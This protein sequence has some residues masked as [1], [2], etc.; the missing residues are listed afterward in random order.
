MKLTRLPILVFFIF[1]SILGTSQ[2]R[3]QDS[4]ALVALYSA[5]D[6]ANWAL[7]TNWLSGSPIN[8]W[9]GV[10]LNASKRV[11]KINLTGNNLTG[12]LPVKIGN[13]DALRLLYLNNNQLTG[14]IPDTLCHLINV[15]TID[16]SY[17]ELSGTIPAD[18]GG[19]ASLISLTL[20]HNH[21][22]GNLPDLSSLSTLEYLSLV[23][24]SFMFSDLSTS[25]L[26]PADIDVFQYSPQDTVTAVERN[27][28]SGTILTNII[29]DVHNTYHWYKN[30]S[31]ISESTREI[32]P[33]E[34]GMYDCQISNTNYPGL[35]L[36]S[37]TLQFS[38][39]VQSDSMVL[40]ALYNATNGTSW[41][42]H[43]NWLIGAMQ[44]W[45]GV[46]LDGNRR[47]S[48]IK[49]ERNNLIGVLPDE[50]GTLS[51][52]E[53]LK[54]R[55]N[56]LREGVPE[57]S[58]CSNLDTLII[59]ENQ[60][61][62]D[63][64]ETVDI[65]PGE[66]ATFTYYPQ[67]TLIPLTFNQ[68]ESMLTVADGQDSSN[69]YLWYLDGSFIDDSTQTILITMEASYHCVITNTIF[70]ELTLF[71]DTMEV[72]F[73]S[74]SDSLM[75]VKLYNETNGAQWANRTN[76]LT[77]R[78]KNWYGITVDSGNRVQKISLPHNKLMGAIPAQI[79]TLSHLTQLNLSNNQL[80]GEIPTEIEK[81]A[82][83]T[84]LRLYSNQLIG[85][86]PSGLGDLTDLTELGLHFNELTGTIPSQLFHLTNLQSLKLSNNQLSGD[87]PV[88]I[89][90]L[91]NLTWL[92][93]NDNLLTGTIPAEIGELPL[94]TGIDLD[95]NLFTGVI[96]TQIGNLTGLI[97]LSLNDNELTGTIPSGISNCTH[98]NFLSLSGNQLSGSIPTELTEL[99]ELTDLL[100]GDNGL[101]G[102]VPAGIGFLTSLNTLDLAKNQFTGSLPAELENLTGL[103]T[104][105]LDSNR[106]EGDL[107]L[108]TG[109]TYL[110]ELTADNNQFTFSNLFSSGILP[111][112]I[113]QFIYSP[114]DTIFG[115]DYDLIGSTLEALDDGETDNTF[116]W[117]RDTVQLSLTSQTISL[118]R[119]G[120]YHCLVNNPHYPDLTIPSDTFL[121][122]YTQLTDSVALVAFYDSTGGATWTNKTNWLTGKLSSWYGVTVS[123]ERVSKV[124]LNNNNLIGSLPPEIGKLSHLTVLQ[125]QNN[126]LD[127]QLPDEIGE[128]D[129]LSDLRLNNNQLT[130]T[131]PSVIG[132][133]TNLKTLY[134]NNNRFSGSIPS[135][136]GNLTALTYLALNSNQLT[137]AIPS[138][139]GNLVNLQTLNLNMNLL[140]GSLPDEIG[141][142]SS[143]QYL[144]LSNNNLSGAIPVVIGNLSLIK[145]INLSGNDFTGE[146]P[147]ETG[148]LDNLRVLNL[149]G[150]QLSGI[151]PDDLGYLS[152]LQEFN[153]GNN[154]YH[155]AA[156][157]PIFNWN[158]YTGFHSLFTYTPQA[159]IGVVDTVY[160]I[161]GSALVLSIEGY[162]T[163]NHDQFQW[164]KNDT[165]Q[166]GKTD[167]VFVISSFAS[168]NEGVYHC[169]V[170][171]SIA[172][173]LTLT[174][175]GIVLQEYTVPDYLSLKNISKGSG[176]TA[177][178]DALQD[179][180]L[181]GSGSSVQFISGSS[182][183]LIAGHSIRF[184]PG[185]H[186]YPGCYIDA[187]ITTTAS[188]CEE[189]SGRIVN[190]TYE[191]SISIQ[192]VSEGNIPKNE[193]RTMMIYPNPNDGN[194]I[195]EYSN[196]EMG[197]EINVYNAQGSIVYRSNVSE[198]ELQ[199]ISL[200]GL[201]KGLYFVNILDGKSQVTKKMVVEW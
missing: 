81:L 42:N 85:S 38:Y 123:G 59:A 182:I 70:T 48:K 192:P 53:C 98:L 188:F 135:Q 22:S 44:S 183:T 30:G 35:R 46:T 198:P 32:T 1:L 175:Y 115:L 12:E 111:E 112:D 87:I 163:A 11:Y 2:N 80:Y 91:V 114:Q 144:Y 201:L 147:I 69:V 94:L 79:S 24:N 154:G 49:L 20:D 193:E 66:I 90:N 168:S 13:L 169:L 108:L 15:T 78:I 52:L 47:V 67:D 89:E 50:L 157:E 138:T 171:N 200:P 27:I 164:Y 124:I 68:P 43:T 137:G 106:F 174:S 179:I 149:S 96:P 170:S 28:L 60:Y 165:L 9:Y 25:G 189:L 140:S 155:F 39:N 40:V 134:L 34:E 109:V 113:D 88:G 162:I 56:K 101:T 131:L 126:L 23:N 191:K 37:D 73:S 21:L 92:A 51:K 180:T 125:L 10:T 187:Y 54:L 166:T 83:L 14:S 116:T 63:D 102:E 100:L 195:L 173:S 117:F 16:L 119:E 190:S 121:Y 143:L 151:I 75:L 194:F 86:I 130:G 71:S 93:L 176:E 45:Y 148:N 18:I 62:F 76:W 145:T 128:M 196:M 7:K 107:P 152:G 95:G 142:L 178:Y 65:L 160:G 105:N 133:L 64:L 129:S 153:I 127:S 132:N 72:L 161:D 55:G 156:I 104:I 77:G 97:E 139:I 17:N 57:L 26:L 82:G 8:T 172:T 33:P 181:A 185:F 6:G 41:V 197:A 4:L 146:V 36:Y 99:G 5:T 110:S 177:C 186:A 61:L 74:V 84:Q 141:N 122:S 29:E 158:N 120:N 150:N 199:Q 159:N 103:I 3:Q 31:L 19:M 58:G 184:L 136:T 167:S 118:T